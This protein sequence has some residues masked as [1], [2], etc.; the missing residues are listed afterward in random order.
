MLLGASLT[1]MKT[2]AWRILRGPAASF[3]QPCT[4]ACALSPVPG[5][6]A[7]RTAAPGPS[8]CRFFLLFLSLRR[9]VFPPSYAISPRV[10]PPRPTAPSARRR[11]RRED[12]GRGE[13]GGAGGQERDEEAQGRPGTHQGC[14]KRPPS[15]P[16]FILI[17][18]CKHSPS[19]RRAPPV[20]GER[21][22]HSGVV[23]ETEA[24][25]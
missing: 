16:S 12:E 20:K 14:Y 3:P 1:F 9:L 4:V 18:P 25:E 2:T 17:C 19:R 23:P 24:A 22:W 8:R 11:R 10:G 13:G 6:P 21:P 15:V 7:D 5:S